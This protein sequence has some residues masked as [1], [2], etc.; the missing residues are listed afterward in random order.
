MRTNAVFTPGRLTTVLDA[1]A[2]SSGKGKLGSYIAEHA[3]NFQFC[4][5]TFGPQAGHWIKLDDGRTFFYQ[6]LNSCAYMSDRYEKMYLG[7]GAMIELP[8]LFREIEENN[9]PSHKLGISPT[10]PILQ[11]IDA[12]FERGEVDLDGNPLQELGLGT[13][14]SGSTCHGVGA[15]KARKILRRPNVLLARDVPELQEFLCDVPNEVMK[16]L[17]SGQAGL[18]EVAQG[19]QLS[20]G[21]DSMYPFCTSRNCTVAAGLDDMMLPPKYAGKVVLNLRTYPIR[22]NNK[23]FIAPDGHH[24]VWDEVQEYEAEGKSYEIKEFNSGPG[25]DDQ[26]EISWDELTKVSGSPDPIIEMTSVTKLPRRVFTFS[27]KN[28]W[29]AI[30]HNDTGY[31]TYLCVNFMNYVDYEV[32]GKRTEADATTKVKEWMNNNLWDVCEAT[33]TTILCLGTGALTDD[34]IPLL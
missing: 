23:K 8:A 6:T 26:V 12:S 31:G 20:Y 14:K 2:G 11:D 7:H 3:D 10:V 4:C 29:Q 25:Y 32:T 5:N 18:L 13:M 30:R 21:L 16:R 27:K 24:M 17:N 34:M 9:I 1:S 22:I 33:D 19:F 28:L 15:C